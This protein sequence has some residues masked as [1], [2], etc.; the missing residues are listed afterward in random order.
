M[1]DSN[2][3]GRVWV[4]KDTRIEREID[5]VDFCG[6]ELHL[7]PGSWHKFI[8]CTFESKVVVN[9]VQ[10]V[11]FN[12]CN[13]SELVIKN[14]EMSDGDTPKFHFFKNCRIG[15]VKIYGSAVPS[16]LNS[17]IGTMVVHAVSKDTNTFVMFSD[18]KDSIV[19]SLDVSQVIGCKIQPYN[20][21]S[22][23]G[24][25]KLVKRHGCLVHVNKYDVFN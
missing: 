4:K 23:G 13:I 1:S 10:H 16:F 14:I 17:K 21:V 22:E 7:K 6:G 20:I 25:L 12:N 2:L 19:W 5:C 3:V 24:D 11:S 8:N 18:M 15:T 9:D